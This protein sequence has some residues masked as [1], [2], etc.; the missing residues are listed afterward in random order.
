VDVVSGL[1]AGRA[2]QLV[3]EGDWARTHPLSSVGYESRTTTVKVRDGAEISVKVSWPDS[4]R[5]HARQRDTLSLPVLFVTHGGGW[6]KG[7]HITEEA[8][9]LWPLYE[10]FDFVV[11]SVEYRVGPEH[12]FP[13]WME[14]SWDV[15]EMIPKRPD[16][17]VNHTASSV[18]IDP[19]RIILAGSSAGGGT[20]AWLSQ[21][22]RERSPSIP[23][24]GVILNVA[25]TCDYRHFP[26]HEFP[27]LA[28]GRTTT[29]YH[30]C[31]DAYLSSGVM[32]AIWDLLIPSATAGSD[33]FV[34]PLLG[35]VTG[36]PRHAIFVAGQDPLRDEG[37]AYARK[38]AN[39][40]VPVQLQVYPGVPHTFAEMWELAATQRFWRDLR[41]AVADWLG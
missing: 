34:S 18:A 19:S 29:S 20:T 31:T 17:F 7:T 32:R 14:D 8:W 37:L 38:L 2:S 26:A 9:L 24:S 36:L 12:E 41:T 40:G 33:P 3:E 6:I 25:I 35:D 13:A 39:S 22:C 15:L 5:I 10:H 11:V 27:D 4:A 23:I 28:H 16:T 21:R 30:Q 1:A